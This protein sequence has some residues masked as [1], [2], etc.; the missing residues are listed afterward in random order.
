[1]TGI[2]LALSLAPA[3]TNDGKGKGAHTYLGLSPGCLGDAYALV[4]SCGTMFY[5]FAPRFIRISANYFY[6]H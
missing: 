6:G 2:T 3:D 5:S 4:V 1:M